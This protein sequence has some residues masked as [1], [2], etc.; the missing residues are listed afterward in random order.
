MIRRLARS[1]VAL[2]ALLIAAPGSAHPLGNN[3]VN[4]QATLTVTPQR[5][6]IRY[7][8]DVAEI[9]TMLESQT[10][11]SDGDGEVAAAE[12]DRY[13]RRWA[14]EIRNAL[15]V[16]IDGV[17]LAL[18]TMQTQYRLV[19]GSA[20]L[21]ILRMEARYAAKVS[22]TGKNVSLTYSDAYKP[23]Q[24]GW[25]AVV[26]TS[27]D[28]VEVFKSTVSSQDKSRGLTDF[29]GFANAAFPDELRAQ[30][31]I[32]F[33]RV[34][35]AAHS[36]AK[37]SD[38]AQRSET[39]R[40][41]V[42]AMTDSSSGISRQSA[43]SIAAAPASEQDAALADSAHG[44]KVVLDADVAPQL[45]T[46][47]RLGMHHIATGWDHLLFLLGLL[48]IRQPAREIIKIVTAFTL[49]HSATLLLAA[50]G[51]VRPPGAFVEAGIALT[52]AYVG[53]MNLR[54]RLKPLPHGVVAAFFFG[55]IHGFGFAGALL[56]SLPENQLLLSI[57]S[58][59][60]G[61]E[62][63]QLMLIVLFVPLVYWASKF[64]WGRPVQYAASL[65]VFASGFGWFITRTLGGYI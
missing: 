29:S 50:A 24:L 59:N 6:E 63:I 25:K 65:A 37:T 43:P 51:W 10:A 7:L 18:K 1:L 39:P 3:A 36:N 11:D 27:G 38:A 45:W 61:I 52:I 62:T 42:E 14:D 40:A 48:I 33:P 4:R 8:F 15:H 64:A 57:A 5:V 47:F 17:P 53:Y 34:A 32:N 26:L 16:S 35:Q 20:D 30:A 19:P 55:L 44:A 28:G 23:E 58:F 22:V 31:E 2:G 60:A 9:P 56:Q 13:S 54:Q 12:W 49:A 46:F 41:T 21:S